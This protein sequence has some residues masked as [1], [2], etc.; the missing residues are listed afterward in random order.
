MA[1]QSVVHR[2]LARKTR[3]AHLL[4]RQKEHVEEGKP[5][6]DEPKNEEREQ[7]TSQ[8]QGEGDKES[9]RRYEEHT[10]QFVN[11]GNIEEASKSAAAQHPEEAE[12]AEQ[13][14]KARAKEEDPAVHREY[15]KPTH[16]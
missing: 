15:H 2:E 12:R 6:T 10:K 7:K 8:I 4:L 5:M 13:A 14:G 3:P 16:E 1:W 9:A 11:S